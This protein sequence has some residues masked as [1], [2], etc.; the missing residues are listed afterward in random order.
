MCDE[1]DIDPSDYSVMVRNIPIAIDVDDYDEDLK[2][3]MA[4]ELWKDDSKKLKIE[5]L[6][7]RRVQPEI[8]TRRKS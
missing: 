3:H 7:M 6:D 4:K 2:E 5:S 1:A 8:E